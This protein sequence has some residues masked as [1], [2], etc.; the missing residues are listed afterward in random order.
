[1][2]TNGQSRGKFFVERPPQEYTTPYNKPRAMVAAATRLPPPKNAKAKRAASAWQTEAFRYYETIGEIKYAFDMVASL[3]SRVRLY[4]A[5]VDDPDMVPVE[6]SSFLEQMGDVGM[7]PAETTEVIRVAQ[8]VVSDLMLHSL[9]LG[10]GLLRDI[11][12][13]VQVVGEVYLVSHENRWM[14]VSPESLEARGGAWRL[15]LDRTERAGGIELPEDTFVARIWK[16][17][18]RF[19]NEPTSSMVG[20]LDSCEALALLDQAMR[21]MTRTRLGAGIIFI[22]DGLT[23]SSGDIEEVLV[24]AVTQPISEETAATIGCPPHSHRPHRIGPGVEA[25]RVGSPS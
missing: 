16:P 10:S 24:E 2:T 22:P 8:D 9:G 4:A 13:C 1:M 3:V 17:S 11:S 14:A 20:V 21:S 15:K 18:A 7:S 25:D 12:T 5:V 19:A 23:A 6:A